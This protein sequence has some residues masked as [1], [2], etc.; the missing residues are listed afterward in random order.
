M[1]LFVEYDESI[2]DILSDEATDLRYQPLYRLI[3]N[4]QDDYDR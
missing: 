3:D 1:P 2:H 4:L